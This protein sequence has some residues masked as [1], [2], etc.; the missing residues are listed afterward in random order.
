[1]AT[2][3]KMLAPPPLDSPIVEVRGQNVMLDSDLARAYGVT[4]ATPTKPS[5]ATRRAF[6]SIFVSR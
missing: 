5:N 6:R 4:T 2:R 3:R 1:M